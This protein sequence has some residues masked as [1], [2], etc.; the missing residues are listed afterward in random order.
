M[1]TAL[2]QL[3]CSLVCASSLVTST[4]SVARAAVQPTTS[5]LGLESEDHDAARA[6]TRALRNQLSGRG[7]SGG[8]EVQLV[9]LRLTMG[10]E[11]DVP[12]CL[13]EGG[14]TLGVDKLVYG[15]LRRKASGYTIDL[16][17]IDVGAGTLERSTTGELESNELAP[18]AIDQTADEL[19]AALLGERR[20][21]VPAPPPVRSEERTADKGRLSWGKHAPVAKWKLG[22]LGTSVVLTAGALG[23]AI[24]TTLAIRRGGLVYDELIQAAQGSLEDEK[25]SND[26]DP[27]S[28]G[29]LCAMARA[30]LEP[31]TI[32]NTAV[33]D[34]CNKGDALAKVAT[35]SWIATGIFAATTVV[36]TTLLFV[37]RERPG[38]AALRRHGVTLGFGPTFHGGLAMSAGARF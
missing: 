15:H 26:I 20:P 11:S 28:S 5:V 2:A 33:N 19:V 13:A 12:S 1:R 27:N 3:V 9:E 34:V 25:A 14:K 30:E 7:H 23:T 21:T 32:T 38:A 36:F 18:R 37:H 24:G 17:V 29:D 16:H 4:L 35:A 31:G 6:L 22:L 10:C 8:Q